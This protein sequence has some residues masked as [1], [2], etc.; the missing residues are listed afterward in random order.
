M[1][2][3]SDLVGLGILATVVNIALMLIK[4]TAGMIGNSYALVADGIESAGDILTS[5]ITWAGFYFSLRPADKSHPYG[6]GKFESL[7]GSFSGFSLLLAAGFI[8]HMAIKE[9]ITPHNSPSWFTLPILILVVVVKEA[10]SRR[11]FSAGNEAGSQAI[12]GDAWHHRSDAITSAAA[13]VGI[14]IS[15][16]GGA[17]YE[18]ADDWAALFACGII[19]FNG[20]MIIKLSLHD[21]LDGSAGDDVEAM[22]QK[23]VAETPGVTGVENVRVRKSGLGI[24]AD[25]HVKVPA[26]ITVLSG[27][28]ISHA[29]KRRIIDEN[30][31]IK[32]IVIHIEPQL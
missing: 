27:H 30:S 28:E 26:D 7:A 10:L 5:M 24:F 3:P 25:M 1:K 6:H 12:K 20:G 13:A 21:V 15:L 4:I 17:G 32:D 19:A 29:A 14:L 9:I 18:M 31:R 8:A 23:I 11:V 2:S 16:V 22:I